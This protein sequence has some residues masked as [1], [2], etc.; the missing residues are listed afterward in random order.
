MK[1]PLTIKYFQFGGRFQ[2]NFGKKKEKKKKRKSAVP[3]LRT[4]W[5]KNG[6][7]ED[8]RGQR[9]LRLLDASF[10]TLVGIVRYVPQS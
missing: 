9:S 8:A 7:T 4:I 3:R 2:S 1:N 10:N 6:M 5:F